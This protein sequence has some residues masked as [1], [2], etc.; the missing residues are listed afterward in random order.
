MDFQKISDSD[1]IQQLYS[2]LAPLPRML[3]LKGRAS[4]IASL[5]IAFLALIAYP[6]EKS[7]TLSVN[8]HTSK[9]E[10]SHLTFPKTVIM[11]FMPRYRVV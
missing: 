9:L 10:Y 11:V 6:H 2:T 7:K 3:P 4:V 5:N 1:S 8:L